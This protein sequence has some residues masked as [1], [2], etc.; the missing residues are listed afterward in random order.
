MEYGCGITGSMIDGVGLIF[1]L[2]MCMWP[3]PGVVWLD[4]SCTSGQWDRVG[5]LIG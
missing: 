4:V 3:G 1:F 2:L 5:W